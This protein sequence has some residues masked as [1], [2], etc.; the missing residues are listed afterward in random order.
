MAPDLTY[1]VPGLDWSAATHT[2]AGAATIGAVLGVLMF[3]G[4]HALFAPLLLDQAPVSLREYLAVPGS[5]WAQHASTMIGGAIV[6]VA[7]VRW[8]RR[9]EPV[10]VPR[11]RQR[12]SRGVIAS[13]LIALPTAGAMAAGSWVVITFGHDPMTWRTAAAV[14]AIRGGTL[15]LV[16]LVITGLLNAG[17]ARH[18]SMGP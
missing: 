2:L 13:L 11:V 5:S 3:A 18:D 10:R 15:L 7:L 14:S 16:M 4:W 9:T 17:A 8:Y 1:Y 12:I 6:V